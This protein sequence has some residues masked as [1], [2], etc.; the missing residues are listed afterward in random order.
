M[1]ARLRAAFDAAA[2]QNRAAL[3]AY[4][5]FGDPDPTTSIAV[6]GPSPAQAPT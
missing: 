4:L 3:V 1:T 6:V 2:K 5:T